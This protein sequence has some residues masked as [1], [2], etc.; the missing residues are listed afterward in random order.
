VKA[1]AARR[2]ISQIKPDIL[3]GHYATNYGFLAALVHFHPLV[4]TVHGSDLLVDFHRDPVNRFFVKYALRQ[5]DLITSPANHMTDIIND[6]HPGRQIRTFQYGVETQLFCLPMETTYRNPYQIIS[7][8]HFEKKYNVELL[9]HAVPRVLAR[10]P[11]A[12]FVMAGDGPDNG[13]LHQLADELGVRS[14]I[15]WLGRT[16]YAEM[17]KLL[18]TSTIYVSTSIS[19]GASLSLLEAMG[20][21]D[22]PIVTDIPA[23]REWIKNGVN[24]FLVPTDNPKQLSERIIQA[25]SDKKLRTG[26]VDKNLQIVKQK[27]SYEHNMEAME[28]LYRSLLSA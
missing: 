22:F 14:N 25:L 3:H 2:I 26:A 24:G 15:R 20:C 4:Q 8:R 21:G 23:N 27:G 16:A 13:L 10:V 17:P 19:D 12:E 9:L 1:W 5:A 18:Q 7:T 6:E 28:G 11:Q